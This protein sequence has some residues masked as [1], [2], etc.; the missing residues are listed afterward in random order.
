[1]TSNLTEYIEA[2]KQLT[3]DERLEAAHQLLL[4]VQDD[5]TEQLPDG[6]EWEAELMRRAGEALD[7]TATLHDVG[8][9]HAKIRTELAALRRK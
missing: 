6:M 5:E 3:L 8:E 9:S 7:G 2:G 4:S 1:M